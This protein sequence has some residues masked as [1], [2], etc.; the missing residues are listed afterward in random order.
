MASFESGVSGYVAAKATVTVTFPIDFRGNASVCCAQCFFFRDA[1]SRC[2]LTGKI[3][4]YPNKYVGSYCP[5]EI[6]N[7]DENV[8]ENIEEE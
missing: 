8:R 4:E 7:T 5:L 1:S 6:V 3:S 2:S